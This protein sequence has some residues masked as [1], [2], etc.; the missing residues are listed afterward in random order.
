MPRGVD[1]R[2]RRLSWEIERT[3]GVHE[4]GPGEKRGSGAAADPN[5]SRIRVVRCHVGAWV[6]AN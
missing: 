3:S 4:R 1:R 5:P 6:E 2:P